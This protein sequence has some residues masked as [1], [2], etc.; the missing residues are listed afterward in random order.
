MPLQNV[1]ST[2]HKMSITYPDLNT[3][4]LTLDP[5]ET[6]GGNRDLIV[7]YS[8]QGDKISSGVM[9]YEQGDE[10]FFLM[11]VQPP[12]KVATEQIPPREYIFIVDV[13]GSMWGFP[14]DISKK[15]LRNL[16]VNL[17]PT[18]K[19]NLVLFSGLSA[20]LSPTS[21]DAT[22]D[23]VA[24]AIRLIDAQKGGGGTEL[25]QAMQ[26]AYAIPRPDADLSR[27]FVIISD[28][29][30]D[31][32]K[33]AFDFV[34][35]NSGNSNFFSFGIGSSVNRYLMEGLAFMGSGEAMI[36]TKPEGADAQAE[37][38]RKY[39]NTPVLTRIKSDFGKF[40]TYDV[41]P[42]SPPDM[43]AERPIIIF[44]KY[45]GKGNGMVTVRGKVG[46]TP[47]AQSFDLSKVRPSESNS[48][49]RY[50]WAREKI[51]LLD[52]GSKGGYSGQDDTVMQAQIR[53]LGLKYNL[54]TNYTSFIAIDEEI[55]KDSTGKLVR[56]KTPSPLPDGVS[57]FAVGYDAPAFTGQSG[58]L[59]FG[60]AA[61]SRLSRSAV[62]EV[63]IADSEDIVA[64]TPPSFPG[65]ED[66]LKAYIARTLVYP[67]HLRKQGIHGTVLVTLI[68]NADGSLFSMRIA[69]SVN[70][71]LD[72]EALRVVASMPKWIPAT[73]SGAPVRSTAVT[74]P[75]TFG[76]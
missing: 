49:I 65:G 22:A 53:D 56:V 25:M 40:D 36:V 43:M 41:E 66:S 59:Y 26:M 21:I 20:T 2:T 58:D 47:N 16:L 55:V 24:K 15:L 62:S 61:K 1:V 70:K 23:N 10:N 67:E 31:I 71:E 5:S 3:A 14:L 18:D 69:R 34:R 9:L 48:A 38:F 46:R 75:I 19:F 64:A 39:I 57:N 33:D 29:Y 8:L 6:N 54:M 45:H 37:K 28:G 52:Y 17:K 44:G 51:K 68:I 13:S 27:S 72:Q 30:I 73:V 32:E 12:K 11:M 7:N 60:G 63:E 4:H 76:S 35:N 50:L 74:V 42:S